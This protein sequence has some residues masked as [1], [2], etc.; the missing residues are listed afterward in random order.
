[1]LPAG[2]ISPICAIATDSPTPRANQYF[3]RTRTRTIEKRPLAPDRNFGEIQ[4]LV[5]DVDDAVVLEK[6]IGSE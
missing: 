2:P 1:M 4:F 6:E 5:S 3:S